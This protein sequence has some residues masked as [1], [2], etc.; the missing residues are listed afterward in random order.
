M[1]QK[2]MKTF[3][4]T[5]HTQTLLDFIEVEVNE[6][7]NYEFD[8][9]MQWKEKYNLEDD[10]MLLWVTHNKHIA[11]SYMY[12]SEDYDK[13]V[14]GNFQDKYPLTEVKTF[15]CPKEN[16]IYESDDGAEGYLII[17]DDKV[18]EQKYVEKVLTFKTE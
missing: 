8:D 6:R 18:V 12:N 14:S 2:I 15:L 5:S 13:V 4:T 17:V 3:Y 16:V 7:C 10:T 1:E 9:V 11:N